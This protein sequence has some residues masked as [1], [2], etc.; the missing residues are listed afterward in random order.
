MPSVKREFIKQPVDLAL[1]S[2][3][4]MVLGLIWYAKTASCSLEVSIGDSF[5]YLTGS[6]RNFRSFKVGGLFVCFQT[7]YT[8]DEILAMHTVEVVFRTSIYHVMGCSLAL[9]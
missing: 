2:Y 9:G 5:N 3:H 8:K 4:C 6:V 1:Y 7:N